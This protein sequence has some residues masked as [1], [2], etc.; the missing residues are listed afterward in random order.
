MTTTTIAPPDASTPGSRL[1]S[2]FDEYGL[3]QGDAARLTGLPQPR[4][5]VYVNDKLNIGFEALVLFGASFDVNPM[6]IKFGSP[7]PKESKNG[8]ALKEDGSLAL[9][10]DFQFPVAQKA[11]KAEPKP[12]RVAPPP[13]SP[14]LE[15]ARM[16]ETS[17]GPLIEALIQLTPLELQVLNKVSHR[18]SGLTWRLLRD[19]GIDPAR[20]YVR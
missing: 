16:V 19:N 12:K 15:S 14:A 9:L 20:G 10:S 8:T 11:V 7:Y 4:I 5:S 1:K 3:S 17:H 13:A 2:L 6:W 18:I